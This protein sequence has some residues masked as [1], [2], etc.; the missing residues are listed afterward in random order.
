M[1]YPP[2]THSKTIL[3]VDDQ[4]E[5][6]VM[7]RWFLISF[8]FGVESARTAQ[9]ALAVFDP[10]THDLVITDNTMPGMSGAEMARLIKR[11]SPTTPVLM[12]SGRLPADQSG[13]DLV[14][15][16]PVHLLTVKAAVEQMLASSPPAV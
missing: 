3:L 2:A 10:A 4:D 8:G 5:Y 13:L 6:R 15:Q 7:A 1:K 14:I 16:K 12:C 11:R 9:E